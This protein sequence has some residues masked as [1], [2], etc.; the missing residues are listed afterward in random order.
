MSQYT[1]EEVIRAANAV[2]SV[3]DDHRSE[4]R[5]PQ[6]AADATDML[7]AYADTLRQSADSGLEAE[8]EFFAR[9]FYEEARE[10][11][12]AWPKHAGSG[13]VGD[14][15]VERACAASWAIA[16]FSCETSDWSQVGS[17]RRDH[18]RRVVTAALAAQGQGEAVAA[19]GYVAQDDLTHL[20]TYS[21]E[22]RAHGFGSYE[23]RISAVP[24]G[25][26][27]IPVF[28]RPA[29]A[30]SPAGV[31]DGWVPT[32]AYRDLYRAYVRVLEAG[33]DR[34][35]SLGGDCDSVE[36]MERTDPS[37]IVARRTLLAAA[38]SA[39]AGVPEGWREALAG[40][41]RY[42]DHETC[43]HENTHRG[44][45]I[46]T[47]CDDCGQKWADDR[48]GFKPHEDAPEVATAR[49]LLAAPSAPEGDGGEG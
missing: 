43:A 39:P 25:N 31:P 3:L 9:D 21:D 17:P 42:V 7:R 20:A 8:R 49:R 27:T 40:L 35:T 47:I 1:P 30:A 16:K 38:P 41:L 29:P 14:E 48:G 26:M 37:L 5:V 36:D 46:W 33:R 10:G 23:G 22:A 4:Y 11:K 34:I 2:D 15:V 44:G 12:K 32:K 18:H 45:A 24:Y 28:L 6:A 13:R 19:C